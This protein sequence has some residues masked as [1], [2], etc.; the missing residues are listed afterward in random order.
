MIECG[1]LPFGADWSDEN[2]CSFCDD[3]I[4]A[5]WLERFGGICIIICTCWGLSAY[6][7]LSYSDLRKV[8]DRCDPFFYFFWLW[9]CIKLFSSWSGAITSAALR[10]KVWEALFNHGCRPPSTLN[11]KHGKSLFRE[12]VSASWV[13]LAKSSNP[14]ILHTHSLPHQV[15]SHPYVR[16]HTLIQ[17]EAES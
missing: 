15:L 5:A 6:I 9:A 16:C 13:M 11:C 1:K 14:K 3:C 17:L 2:L 4:N 7:I 10:T 8:V 12:T